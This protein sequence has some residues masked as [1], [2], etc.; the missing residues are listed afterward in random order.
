MKEVG[1]FLVFLQYKLFFVIIS[2][3]QVFSVRYILVVYKL[4]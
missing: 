4:N 1:Y 3:M 2:Q